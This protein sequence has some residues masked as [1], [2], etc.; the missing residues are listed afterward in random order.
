LS[1]QKADYASITLIIPDAKEDRQDIAESKK[2]F[3]GNHFEKITDRAHA[4]SR[5]IEIG[6]PP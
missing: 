3:R 6:K 2:G 4:I 5:S 1:D